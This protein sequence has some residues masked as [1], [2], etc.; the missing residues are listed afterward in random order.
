MQRF[1]RKINS[2]LPH[3]RASIGQV[4]G[5]TRIQQESAHQVKWSTSEYY[6]TANDTP[7][8]IVVTLE[9]PFFT[10]IVL[11]VLMV[12]LFGWTCIGLVVPIVFAI[13]RSGGYKRKMSK[14]LD[15]LEH[16]TT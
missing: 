2:T 14:Q 12:V 8:G 7:S 4:F 10:E 13:L 15:R 3:V 11:I 1:S 16:L 5:R 6:I 9:R